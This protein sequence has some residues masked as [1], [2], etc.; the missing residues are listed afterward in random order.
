LLNE[1]LLLVLAAVALAGSLAHTSTRALALWTATAFLFATLFAANTPAGYALVALPLALL[2]GQ[3]AV[4]VI[5]RLQRLHGWGRM[6]AVYVLFVILVAF[7]FL[8][9]AGLVTD[10]A[11]RATSDT[12][13]RFILVVGIAIIP[14]GLGLAVLGR[15]LAGNRLYLVLTAALLVLTTLTVRAAVLSATERPG[16]PGDPLAAGVSG[17]DIPALVQ[18][19]DKISRDLTLR[20]RD[21]RDPSGGHGLSIA[22]D[23]AIAQPFAWYFRDYYNAAIFDPETELPHEDAQVVLLDGSRDVATIAP[24]LT[25]DL[26]LYQYGTPPLYES[27]NWGNMV[28]GTFDLNGWRRFGDL[29]LNRALSQPAEASYFQLYAA[30]AVAERLF[31]TAGPYGLDER[32]GAGRVEGQFIQ[33]RGI[34]IDATGTIF[35]VDSGNLRVQRFSPTGQFELSWGGPGAAAGEFGLFTGDVAQGPGGIAIGS[36]GNIYVADTWNHRIQVFTSEG[37][38]LRAWGSFFD[39][40]DDPTL[41]EEQTGSFYGPRGIAA[42]DGL[43]YVTDTGNERVQVF[44]EDGAVVRAFGMIGSELGQLLEPVGIAVTADGIIFVADSHN[45]RIARF[46]LDGEPL[47]AWPVAGWDALRFF[48]PYLALAPDGLLYATN[49]AI[50][51]VVVLDA[52]GTEL[53]PLAAADIQRPYGIAITPGG[54]QAL[55]T[56]G[57]TN[58]VIRANAQPVQP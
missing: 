9:L 41:A 42:H 12:I 29:L 31:A 51:E 48:E 20:E 7:A 28:A 52:D 50:G 34:A 15:R 49:S 46:T 11:P 26:Y 56:D 17:S 54:E 32:A 57:I 21:A 4:L 16:E 3:G 44:T 27:P 55:V 39:A 58:A 45:A 36:D 1:P 24:G 10:P 8:S 2:A 47:D 43:L 38:Y 5:E 22:I 14:L 6:A 25:G 13:A 53:G 19:L 23:E 37:E 33:P 35:V 40:A 30:P 18:V